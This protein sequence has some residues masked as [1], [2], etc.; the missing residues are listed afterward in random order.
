MFRSTGVE[1]SR[2]YLKWIAKARDGERAQSVSPLVRAYLNGHFSDAE[3]EEIE[4]ALTILLDDPCADVRRALAEALAMHLNAPRHLILA[5]TQDDPDVSEPVY[6]R[7]PLLLDGELI[8]AVALGPDLTQA[9][10]ARRPR[11]SAPVCAAICEVAPP[12][13]VLMLLAN[14]KAAITAGAYQR[15]VDRFAEHQDVRQAIYR[16]RD[17]PLSVRQTLIRLLADEVGVTARKRGGVPERKIREIVRD[18]CDRATINLLASADE[19]DMATLVE[20]LRASGQLTASL[21]IRAMCFGHIRFFEAALTNLADLPAEK[22]FAILL[23]RREANL[24]AL[25][26]KGELPERTHP[27]FI[28]ALECWSE[29]NFDEEPAGDL[30]FRRRMVERILAR[31]QAGATSDLDDLLIMLRRLETEAA[32]EAARLHAARMTRDDAAVAAIAAAV[33]DDEAR[34]RTISVTPGVIASLPAPDVIAA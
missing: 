18:A 31:Y 16:R 13:A 8:D 3:R 30:R 9:A 6:E 23:E 21:L 2:R 27:A 24:A 34:P 22:V 14:E 10:I 12:S 32:R 4:A 5:L 28:A 11:V 15:L 7:S 17:V 29:A 19:E 26:S 25:F 33:V 1:L 20:H